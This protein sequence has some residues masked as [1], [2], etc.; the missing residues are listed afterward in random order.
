MHEKPNSIKM[1]KLRKRHG[2]RQKD[3]ADMIG[4]SLRQIERYEHPEKKESHGDMPLPS[5]RLFA[6][7]CWVKTL[8][9]DMQEEV[10]KLLFEL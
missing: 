10:D 4:V 7:L 5:L 2:L 6:I 3:V 9:P 8:E 1:K